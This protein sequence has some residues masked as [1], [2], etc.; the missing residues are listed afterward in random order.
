MKQKVLDFMKSCEL[1]VIS[2]ADAS[3]KP[4]A[5]LV[6]FSENDDLELCIATTADSRKHKNMTG[7]PNV[8][9]VIGSGNEKIAIQYEGVAKPLAGDELQ[10]R[11]KLHFDKLPSAKKFLDQSGQVYY[12]IMPTWIRYVDANHGLNFEEMEF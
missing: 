3:G 1:C 4:E 10:S 7:N 6:G 2:T 12:K 11:L 5:A 9:I 8:A